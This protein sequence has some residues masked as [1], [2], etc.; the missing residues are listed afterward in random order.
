MTNS[1]LNA[2]GRTA[3][4]ALVAVMALSAAPALAQR[5]NINSADAEELKSLPGIGNK[6]AREIVKNREA[7][8]P[9]ATVEDLARVPGISSGLIVKLEAHAS[10]GGGGDGALVIQE[11][12]VVTKKMVR[13]VLARF[14]AEPTIREVQEAALRYTRANPKVVDSWRWRARTNAMLPELRTRVDGKL[15]RNKRTRIEIGAADIDNI[16]DNNSVRMEARATW[17]LDRLV[18]E[19]QELAIA[20]ETVRMS[21]LR[22][23]VLDEVTRRYFERRRLQVD[24]ELSPPTDL[25]DRVRKELRVQ[26][27]TADLDSVTG[28]WFSKQLERIGRDPY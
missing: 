22:D 15:D 7:E 21:N 25:T 17:D 10:A 6:L 26:E 9:F 24:L 18:F 4:L 5:V 27:L 19:P 14:A 2:W 1:I 13:S 3:C 20:R 28:S 16:D 11:G 23:R 12:E 8:G